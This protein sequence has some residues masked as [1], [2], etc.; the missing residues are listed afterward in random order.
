[1]GDALAQTYADFRSLNSLPKVS[2]NVTMETKQEDGR[3]VTHIQLKNQNPS[4]A[5]FIRL[6]LT[7]C[8]HR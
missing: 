1:M 3:Q 4:L 6:N 7:S 5:F 2:V 8:A